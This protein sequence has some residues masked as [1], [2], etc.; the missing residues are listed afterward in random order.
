L[1]GLGKTIQVIAFLSAV[2]GK[3]GLKKH[4]AQ[5]RKRSINELAR[6]EAFP[7]PSAHGQTC[8]VICPASVVRNWER[9]FET[10]RSFREIHVSITRADPLALSQW[11]YLDVRVYGG[12]KRQEVLKMF[13]LGYIDVRA[14]RWLALSDAQAYSTRS[15]STVIAGIEA[16][17]SNIDE[18]I[19][20]DFSMIIV[21]EAHRVKNP[22]S[23]TTMALH[24]FP[25]KLRYGLTGTAIQNG[26]DE[27]WCILDWAVPGKVGSRQQW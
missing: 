8:L 16:V 11:S 14:L 27:F 13:S 3:K 25:T 6:G 21:D 24:Q 20:H 23:Q 12:A 5:R 4:D 18:L 10:V 17:R 26:L 2:M 1:P 22:L 19:D 9:E 7:A 15:P